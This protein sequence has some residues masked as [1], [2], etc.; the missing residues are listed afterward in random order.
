MKNQAEEGLNHPDYCKHF[1]NASLKNVAEKV[2]KYVPKSFNGFMAKCFCHFNQINSNRS[3][4]I[5]PHTAWA[6]KMALT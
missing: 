2:A 5:A 6:D 3:K 1:S 4:K